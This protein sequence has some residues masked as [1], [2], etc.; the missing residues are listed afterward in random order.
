MPSAKNASVPTFGAPSI[1][2]Q[3]IVVTVLVAMIAAAVV[4]QGS[5][6][7]A[8]AT[9]RKFSNA[10]I[11]DVDFTNAEAGWS[12]LQIDAQ[13]N[14]KINALTET[15][16][17]DAIA[18]MQ[19]HASERAMARMALLLERQFGTTGSQQIMTLLPVLKAYKEAELRWWAEHG[20][21]NPLPHAALFKLQDSLLGELLAD[22]LFSEQRRLLSMMQASQQIRDN[23]ELTP[24]EKEEALKNLQK[25]LQTVN[26]Q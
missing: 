7:G 25:P 26:A 1:V 23:A 12:G 20:N 22:K 6:D 24:A 4:W 9:V 2:Q 8:S 16:L 5:E 3:R 21:K 17:Q 15:A 18:V 13:G 10:A 11:S 14:L 19:N